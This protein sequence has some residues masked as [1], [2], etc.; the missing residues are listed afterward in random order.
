ME[1]TYKKMYGQDSEMAEK[2]QRH[3]EK[4]IGVEVLRQYISKINSAIEYNIKDASLAS[5]Y[6]IKAVGGRGSKYYGI[7]L[8]KGKIKIE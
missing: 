3:Y 5:I 1:N 2:F 6:S 4:G 7:R 8:E